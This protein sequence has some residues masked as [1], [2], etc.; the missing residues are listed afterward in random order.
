MTFSPRSH[1]FFPFLVM[2]LILFHHFL[3][4]KDVRQ[5]TLK[6]TGGCLHSPCLHSS[7]RV[8]VELSITLTLYLIA[9]CVVIAQ[10][11]ERTNYQLETDSIL[12]K[13]VITASDGE[14]NLMEELFGRV[15]MNILPLP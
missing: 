7:F 5:R 3:S 13:P 1:F 4:K 6:L 15:R 2:L 10:L 11:T 14:I 9:L 8:L 12:D